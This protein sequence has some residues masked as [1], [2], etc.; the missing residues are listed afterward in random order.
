MTVLVTGI[1]GFIGM[2]TA[3]RLLRRGEAVVGIDN[4]N[5]YY[6]A[7][8]KE[9][10]IAELEKLGGNLTVHRV[11]IGD[12]QALAS[13][14]EDAAFEHIGQVQLA[15][16]AH[17]DAAQRARQQ[18]RIEALEQRARQVEEMDAASLV[19]GDVEDVAGECQAARTLEQPRGHQLGHR[20]AHHLA[21]GVQH[22]VGRDFPAGLRAAWQWLKS[23]FGGGAKVATA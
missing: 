11:D 7:R 22:L 9:A 23:M 14:L 15:V 18:T 12:E 13:S 1:A 3:A 4:F 10:R 5:D 2:H 17:R 8:L 19:V 6:P 20:G 16:A 21:A